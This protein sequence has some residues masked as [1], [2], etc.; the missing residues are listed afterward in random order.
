MARH[1]CVSVSRMV[2][3]RKRRSAA[4]VSCMQ[5]IAHALSGLQEML[6]GQAIRG[7]AATRMILPHVGTDASGTVENERPVCRNR[8][9]G[10]S[11]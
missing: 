2:S 10:A 5:T 8:S 1:S 3:L 9:R 7:K 4:R 11:P 6:G